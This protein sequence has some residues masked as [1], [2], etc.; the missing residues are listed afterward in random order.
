MH[1]QMRS[2]GSEGNSALKKKKNTQRN[3]AFLGTAV[4]ATIRI[5]EI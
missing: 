1:D 2:N 4:S 3:L 5:R